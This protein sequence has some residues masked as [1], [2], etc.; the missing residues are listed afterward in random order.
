MKRST[1]ELRL[2]SI[3]SSKATTA[4]LK[5]ELGAQSKAGRELLRHAGLLDMPFLR[6]SSQAGV[7]IFA[8]HAAGIA[9]AHVA[10]HHG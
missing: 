8:G 4:S 7:L 10:G 3:T 1:Y 9:R 2:V 6:A 5:S